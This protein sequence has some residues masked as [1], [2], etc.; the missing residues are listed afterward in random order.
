[1]ESVQDLVGEIYSVEKIFKHLSW[2]RDIN[3]HYRTLV[4]GG[5]LSED[6]DVVLYEDGGLSNVE[7]EW[8]GDL[9]NAWIKFGR[10]CC[11]TIQRDPL[12]KFCN[13]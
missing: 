1:M 9:V 3:I 8:N 6:R 12:P 2:K 13:A 4:E 10:Y 11:S 7:Q 5:G